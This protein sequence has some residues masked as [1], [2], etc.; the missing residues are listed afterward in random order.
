MRI[1]NNQNHIYNFDEN[2]P[3]YEGNATKVYNAIDEV[4]NRRVCL[5]IISYKDLGSNGKSLIHNEIIAL[6]R[7][8]GYTNN[9]P[10]VLDFWADDKTKNY[11]IVMQ[12]I[13]G[14]TL[15]DKQGIAGKIEFNQWMISLCDTLNSEHKAH[16]NHKDIKPENI[17]ISSENNVYLIDF[18]ISIAKSNLNDGTLFYRAPEMYQSGLTVARAQ[19]DIFS[20]GVIMYEFY[21]GI[22]PK[23]GVNYS[24]NIFGGGTEWAHFDTPQSICEKMPKALSDVITRCMMLNPN[25]RYNKALDLKYDLK[26]I[27]KELRAWRN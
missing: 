18:N 15:R 3:I 2:K 25:A 27:S 19:S 16:I 11:Y 22:L 14:Q 21:T 5:K 6:S 8:G 23:D 12:L 1:E 13:L 4:L 9:I 7:A 26:K 20:L 24:R 10:I 17:I